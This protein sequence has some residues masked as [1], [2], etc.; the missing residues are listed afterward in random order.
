MRSGDVSPILWRLLT[1]AVLVIAIAA[2]FRSLAPNYL[3]SDN[4][5]ALF[6]HMSE[7]GIVAV[8]LTFVI[9]VRR[10]DLSLPG[11]ASFG[12]MTLGFALAQSGNLMLP[13]FACVA[14]GLLFGLLNGLI[15]G[16]A[17]LPD[18]VATIATGSIAYGLSYVY[19]GGASFSDNFFSSGILDINDNRILTV[20]EPVVVLAAVAAVASFVLN[21]TRYGAAFY[22][23]GE[24][25]V[26][27]ALSG[28]PVR[29]YLVAAFAICSSLACLAM[30]LHVAAGGAAYVSSGNQIL[31]PAYTGVFLGAALFQTA[32][33]PATIAGILVIA[34]ML[35][36][37][38]ALN[39][40]YYFSDAIICSVLIVAV[41]VFNPALLAAFLRFASLRAFGSNALP[42]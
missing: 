31:L 27:A 2:I 21:A 16:A 19:N 42:T 1:F 15:V 24:N 33:V 7:Q 6:R 3:S 35:N 37:F 8:G 9:V 30:V 10:F 13:V 14:A 20:D 34:M 22:A 18:V 40:P 25:P 5:H 28:I 4:L 17:K 12:A 39:V 26:S 41:V 36:G 11:V 38:A 23:T 29:A 32:S